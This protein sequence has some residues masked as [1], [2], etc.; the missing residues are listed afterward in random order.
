NTED[1]GVIDDAKQQ[2]VEVVSATNAKF[3]HFDYTDVPKGRAYLH[4]AWSGNVGSAFYFLPEG[5]TAPDISYYWPG[6]TDGIPGSVEN[7][8]VTIMKTA[9]NPVLAHMFID[10]ILDTQNATTNY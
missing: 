2:I 6:S 7:D 9:Q 10:F 8:T 4:Q 3:D 5:D 1:A